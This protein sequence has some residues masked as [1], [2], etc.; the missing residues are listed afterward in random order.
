MPPLRFDLPKSQRYVVLVVIALAL[1]AAAV[2]A[3]RHHVVQAVLPLVIA[4][5]LGVCYVLFMHDA[6]TELSAWGIVNKR[7]TLNHRVAWPDVREVLLD[8]KTGNG[9][10]VRPHHGK[11]FKLASPSTAPANPDPQFAEHVAQILNYAKACIP[12]Q[13]SYQG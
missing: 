1:V 7:G 10:L 13:G 8:P 9:V 12:P 11:A 3:A 4:I 6:Y 2:M 5:A